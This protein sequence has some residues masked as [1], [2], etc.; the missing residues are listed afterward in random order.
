[1]KSSMVA[2]PAAIPFFG[3][4]GDGA[5][6]PLQSGQ[7]PGIHWDWYEPQERDSALWSLPAATADLAASFEK[8]SPLRLSVVSLEDEQLRSL[9]DELRR[10]GENVLVLD[11]NKQGLKDLAST[12][13]QQ[14]RRY[15]EIQFFSHGTDGSFRVGRNVVSSRTLWRHSGA[16]ETIGQAL[17]PGGDLLLY[18]CNLAEGSKGKQLIERLA[19]I[20]GADV[21]ASTDLTYANGES[22][23]WDLEW[24]VG[25]VEERG[26]HDVLTGLNWQGS[27][28]G[29]VSISSSTL[30]ISN[31]SGKIGVSQSSAGIYS[32]T[33]DSPTTI[34]SDVPINNVSISGVNFE[35]I[36][37]NLDNDT[38]DL[39]YPS[40]YEVDLTGLAGRTNNAGYQTNNDTIT[41]SGTIN[42]FG[43][44]INL[45]SLRNI[46]IQPSDTAHDVT[47][48]D[49]RSW[50][51]GLPE[52]NAGA[53]SILFTED[54]P[55]PPLNIAVVAPPKFSGYLQIGNNGVNLG[56]T[57]I[58][59]EDIDIRGGF[60]FTSDI[61]TGSSQADMA[62][63]N[64]I[65]S[66]AYGLENV[67]IPAMVKT[68]TIGTEL[69][70]QN[71]DMISKGNIGIE[72]INELQQFSASYGS[73]LTSSL[74]LEFAAAVTTG[75]VEADLNINNSTL[76]SEIGNIKI[77]LENS[78]ETTADATLLL[79]PVDKDGKKII[80]RVLSLQQ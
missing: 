53:L 12:L 73:V 47:L 5:L 66:A 64:L 26:F 6:N 59:A 71:V 77:N 11:P 10:Q 31:A 36:G 72:V 27:L 44:N 33:G 21:A 14:G 15:D 61:K 79:Y 58:F 29:D 54:L 4:E 1:M 8:G 41:I 17:T 45:K 62:L 28:G 60:S 50:S 32:I 40:A 35:V 18:G 76:T 22:S 46:R 67:L 74:S 30:S 63:G 68:A 38:N 55:T 23:D 52:E 80:T 70:F 57:K 69:S 16:L 65:D 43:G 49:T 19:T 9:A 34:A 56:R 20:T 75:K 25:S 24:S 39:L 3:H 78:N 42:T 7:L 13:R 48:I 51:N 2:F 37:I